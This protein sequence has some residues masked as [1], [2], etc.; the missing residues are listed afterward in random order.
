MTCE[1][2]EPDGMKQITIHERTYKYLLELVNKHCTNEVVIEQAKHDNFGHLL[3]GMLDGNTAQDFECEK[4]H[5]TTRVIAGLTTK[6][7]YVCKACGDS[8][9]YARTEG[10]DFWFQEDLDEFMKVFDKLSLGDNE[11][12]YTDLFHELK[13]KFSDL[14]IYY[15]MIDASL[16]HGLIYESGDGV[17][18]RKGVIPK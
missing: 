4:C 1:M 11:V 17:Y 14:E 6:T 3:Y 15:L 7:E 2:N 16:H 12:K 18:A 13:D 9:K 5:T 10:E 8:L